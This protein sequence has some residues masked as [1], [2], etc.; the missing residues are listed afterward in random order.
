MW[1]W[2]SDTDDDSDTY[3]CRFLSLSGALLEVL[4]GCLE[5]LG[6]LSVSMRFYVL[7]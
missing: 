1:D 5:S 3:L 7:G 2:D 4:P 6:V